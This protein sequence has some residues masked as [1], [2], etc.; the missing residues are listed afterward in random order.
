MILN[1]T[2]I[3]NNNDETLEE[4]VKILE[5]LKIEKLGNG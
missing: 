3:Q 5:V 2:L 1:W 4:D